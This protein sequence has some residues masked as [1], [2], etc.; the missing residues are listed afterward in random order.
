MKNLMLFL[1][2]GVAQTKLMCELD[3]ASDHTF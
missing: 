1:H 3:L 2:H